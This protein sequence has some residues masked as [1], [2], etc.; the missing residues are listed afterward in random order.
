MEND[1]Q[2]LNFKSESRNKSKCR[3]LKLQKPLANANRAIFSK[4]AA[5]FGHSSLGVCFGFRIS[6]FPKG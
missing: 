2:V 5:E 6:C 4:S 1:D 3:K